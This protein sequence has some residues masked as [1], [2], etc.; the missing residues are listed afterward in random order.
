MELTTPKW[1]ILAFIDSGG[2]ANVMKKVQYLLRNGLWS[3]R[4]EKSSS[5]SDKTK[6]GIDMKE[7]LTWKKTALVKIMLDLANLNSESIWHKWMK[8]Y[9]VK[10]ENI[11]TME[12]AGYILVGPGIHFYRGLT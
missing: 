8:E 9:V 1:K 7:V 6:G 5:R 12:A 11:W 3:G 4:Q 10:E 2:P